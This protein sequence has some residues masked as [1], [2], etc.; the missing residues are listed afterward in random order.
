MAQEMLTDQ[1]F[2][3]ANVELATQG[4]PAEGRMSYRGVTSKAMLFLAITAVCAA[5]G[6]NRA[7]EVFET[8][9]SLWF[10]IGYFILI[11]ITIWAAALPQWA[12][13]AG[14]IYAVMQG[15]WMGAISRVYETAWDG[16]VAQALLTTGVVFLSCMFLYNLEVVRITP[17]F[18][19]ALFIAT[20]GI[21][22]LYV[23]GLILNLFGVDIIFW[24]EPNAT[25]IIVSVIIAI[26]A[27]L[28]L[29]L[30]F[31]FIDKGVR[32]GAPDEMEWYASFGLLATILWLY[33][34][35]LRV[36]RLLRSNQ[37]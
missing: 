9:S 21:L 30:D 11:G 28:N 33:L 18:R 27:A 14:A 1:T 22:L 13:I 19:R 16:I 20:G 31:D 10:L 17:K 2:S 32:M 12:P 8:T 5:I 24:N 23:A 26:I 6:W 3:P 29:F 34:E 35:V 7:L 25:G 4:R 36:L 37:N 15:L